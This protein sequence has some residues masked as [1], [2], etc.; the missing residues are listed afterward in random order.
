MAPADNPP[1]NPVA[2]AGNQAGL[3]IHAA[4]QIDEDALLAVLRSAAN[5]VAALP[6]NKTVEVLIQGPG[7][8]L[9]VADSSTHAAVDEFLRAGT[10]LLACTNSLRSA[11]VEPDMLTAGVG[12][13]PAAITHLAIRQWDGWAYARL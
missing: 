12:T 7:V 10:R 13:V 11:N 9:L 3:L 4:G 8:K 2:T 5:A 1:S 6:P